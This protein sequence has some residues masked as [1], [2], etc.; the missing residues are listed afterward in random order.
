MQYTVLPKSKRGLNHAYCASLCLLSITSPLFAN[1]IGG[2]VIGGSATIDYGT[3][4]VINQVTDKAIINWQDFSVGEGQTTQFVQPSSSSVTLNRVVGGNP[5][6]ILGNL[7]ANGQVFL[8][9]PNGIVFGP[10]AH[11]DVAGLVASTANIAN[12]DFMAGNYHFMNAPDGSYIENHGT[13]TI[14]DAGMAILVAP[15]VKNFGLINAH[16]GDIVLA[17]GKSYTLDLYGDGLI[18][19]DANVLVDNGLVENLGTISANG[20]N[21]L[22]TAQAADTI[23]ES[24]INAGGYIEATSVS[25]HHGHIVLQGY[26]N[27]QISI[28]GLIN[29]SGDDAGE[30]GG[31]IQASA[32]Y[33]KLLDGSVLNASGD[34]GGGTIHIGSDQYHNPK[35]DPTLNTLGL[36]ASLRTADYVYMADDAVIHADALTH[37]DGGDVVLWADKYT[38]FYGDISAKGGSIDGNGGRIETSGYEYLDIAGGHVDT[39]SPVG[40]TGEW[41]LDPYNVEISDL[42]TTNPEYFSGGNPNTYTPT[43]N[44]TR[45]NIDDISSN[46]ASANVIIT[47]GSADGPQAGNVTFTNSGTLTWSNSNTF[48]VNAANNIIWLGDGSPTIIQNTGSGNVVLNADSDLSGV[49]TFSLGFGVIEVNN[50]SIIL[51]YI[52]ATSYANEISFSSNYTITGSGSFSAQMKVY[53]NI[54]GFGLQ[55][56]SNNLAGDYILVQNLATGLGSFTPLGGAGTVNTFSGSLDGDGYTISGLTISTNGVNNVGLIG[57][58]SSGAVLRDITLSSPSVTATD[59]GG[60]G[61]SNIGILIGNAGSGTSISGDITITS[62]SLSASTTG[63]SVTNVGGM[64]GSAT[65]LTTSSSGS[66]TF[67]GTVSA[68]SATNV[69]G[70]FGSLT[71]STVYNTGNSGTI[72]GGSNVAGNVGSMTGST[73]NFAY[74][75]GTITGISNVAGIAGTTNSGSTI[76]NAFFGG[77]VTGSGSNIG[78]VVGENNGTINTALGVGTIS[79]GGTNRGVLIGNNSGTLTNGLYD[80]GVNSGLGVAGANSGSLSYIANTG[81]VF[82]QSAIYTSAGFSISSGF[83]SL[84]SGAGFYASLDWCG[85]ACRVTIST[86]DSATAFTS[87]QLSGITTTERILETTDDPGSS[88]IDNDLYYSLLLDY[89]YYLSD[90]FAYYFGDDNPITSAARQEFFSNVLLLTPMYARVEDGSSTDDSSGSANPTMVIDTEAFGQIIE[91]MIAYYGCAS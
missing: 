59:S 5:S 2:D 90:Y 47:T 15:S 12:D 31:I 63:G 20:G 80:S 71:S 52:P 60:V 69:A 24:L 8:V 81:S 11:I 66:L 29:A 36:L 67:G 3:T 73:L 88:Y 84:T 14:A 74:N 50:G 91:A 54:S 85:S 43:D 72:S 44:S 62:G 42:S 37:G 26:D 23:L 17:S 30:S 9:N 18:S 82:N 75:I 25:E 40:I 79:S 70:L 7:K 86:S 6:E 77:T 27:S 56:I 33:I 16:M 32:N 83:W 51:T 78:G 21:I 38:W 58:T 89:G 45:I 4:T 13:I 10:N 28:S 49:G 48:T 68:S 57:A 41:L 46:L 1:P 53:D 22:L 35:D 34:N 19:F 39:S 65:S 87:Q 76:S 61:I 55:D 64:I